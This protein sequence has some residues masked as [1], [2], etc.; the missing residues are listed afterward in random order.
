MLPDTLLIFSIDPL[1]ISQTNGWHKGEPSGFFSRR[2]DIFVSP[3]GGRTGN[4]TVISRNFS[5]I[6]D[7]GKIL[8]EFEQF[9]R[10]QINIFAAPSA[11]SL[12]VFLVLT[13]LCKQ[14]LLCPGL[15]SLYS[16][17]SNILSNFERCSGE[18]KTAKFS[19]GKKHFRVKKQKNFRL[20]RTKRKENNQKSYKTVF[21]H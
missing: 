8:A 7:F 20:R 15:Y 9:S 11:H 19:L 14:L 5:K 21:G 17:S 18:K 4:G 3:D 6:H 2:Q 1:G 12:F 13:A 10:K 16:L